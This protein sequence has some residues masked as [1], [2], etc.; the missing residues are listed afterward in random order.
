MD[1]FEFTRQGILKNGAPLASRVRPTTIDEVV[2]QDPL[3]GKDKLLYRSIKADRI[4]S[5][6][7]YGP[8]GTGKT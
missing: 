2:G 6:I 5:L 4:S 8:P 1:L 7:F 3:L